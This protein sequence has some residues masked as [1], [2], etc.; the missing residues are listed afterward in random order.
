MTR[1]E[2]K[3]CLIRFMGQTGG[4]QAPV[5]LLRPSTVT[6]SRV[7]GMCDGTTQGVTEIHTMI[8]LSNA[9]ATQ[10]VDEEKNDK[11]LVYE[12]EI[13]D[14]AERVVEQRQEEKVTKKNTKG[15]V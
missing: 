9:I 5:T 4:R 3:V 6:D 13:W 1:D 12:D 2:L 7:I 14:L 15:A 10:C 8:W 11:L